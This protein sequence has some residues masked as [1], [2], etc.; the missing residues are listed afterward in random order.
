[1]SSFS[2]I[3]G[4][5]PTTAQAVTPSDTAVN[6]FRRVYVGTGGNLSVEMENGGTVTF[7]AVPNG[8]TLPIRTVRIRATGTT[9]SNILGLI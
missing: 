2:S 8:T 4:D 5:E 3:P 9:A 6:R 7:T 1:M